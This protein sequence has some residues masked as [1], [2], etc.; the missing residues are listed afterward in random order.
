MARKLRFLPQ[1]HSLVEVTTRTDHG[2]LLM[3][4]TPPVTEAI[5]GVIGKAQEKS[6]MVIHAFAFLTN[7]YHFLCSPADTKQQAEFFGFLNANI[8]KEVKRLVGWTGS[9]FWSRRYQSIGVSNENEAQL[10]RLT[11]LLAQGAKENLVEKSRDWPGPHVVDALTEGKELKG[12][13]F[14]RTG[15]YEARRRRRAQDP[16]IDPSRFKTEQ[17]IRLTPMPCFADQPLEEQRAA[18]RGLLDQI[19]HDIDAARNERSVSALGV[20]KVQ[21]PAIESRPIKPKRSPAPLFHARSNWVRKQLYEAYRVF[22]ETFRAAAEGLKR[23]VA[24]VSFPEGCFPPGLPYRPM[25][26]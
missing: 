20:A 12:T 22:S 7:H 21:Q 17:V 5:L 9:H 3:V 19:D 16:E 24:E 2:A 1:A 18:V 4:P 25:N 26:V 23:G 6:G 14:D 8:A 15:F 13:W 11:Y 10:E